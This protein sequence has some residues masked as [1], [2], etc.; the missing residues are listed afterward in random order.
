[1]AWGDVIQELKPFEQFNL[2]DVSRITNK[3]NVQDFFTHH[4][5]RTHSHTADCIARHQPLVEETYPDDYLE[6]FVNTNELEEDFN[7]TY[8]NDDHIT[9]IFPDHI[10]PYKMKNP[11]WGLQKAIHYV[12]NQALDKSLTLNFWSC[13]F[14]LKLNTWHSHQD[15]CTRQSLIKYVLNDFFAPTNLFFY[16]DNIQSSLTSG[17]SIHLNTISTQVKNTESPSFFILSDSHGKYLPP[18]LNTSQ[19][20]LTS[21]FISGLQWVNNYDNNFCARSHLLSP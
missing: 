11:M 12:F 16:F 9:C 2:F 8:P 18:I 20:I 17:Q 7:P 15:K 13:G 6:C 14:D 3:L 10:R 19:Y 4:W 5:N 21:K 1:M